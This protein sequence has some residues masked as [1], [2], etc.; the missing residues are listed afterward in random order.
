MVNQFNENNKQIKE[1]NKVPKTE[2][3]MND[4]IVKN[5]EIQNECKSIDDKVNDGKIFAEQIDERLNNILEPTI[6]ELIAKYE[7]KNGLIDECDDLFDVCEDKLKNIDTNLNEQLTKVESAIEKLNDAGPI[8]N[9]SSSDRDNKAFVKKV[10]ELTEQGEKLR[11]DLEG[12]QQDMQDA[13]DRLMEVIQPLNELGDREVKTPEVQK[14]LEKLKGIEKE[15]KECEAELVET[16][17]ESDFL[18]DE[19]D[20]LIESEKNNKI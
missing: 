8:N 4:L 17:K 15:L 18:C 3:E 5:K 6:P 11:T 14:I 19:V 16:K 13:K 12:I 10:Q 2:K 7:E 9:P 20:K 1:N